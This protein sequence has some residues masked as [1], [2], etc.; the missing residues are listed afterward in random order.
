MWPI[1]PMV[2]RLPIFFMY[3]VVSGSSYLQCGNTSGSKERVLTNLGMS[4]E[5]F[6]FILE[7]MMSTA[8]SSGRRRR[9]GG[10][11]AEDRAQR[12]REEESGRE[13]DLGSV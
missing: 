12:E 2:P 1:L 7:A 11:V 10:E 8:A 9:G 13:A 5:N 4:K 3:I 6:R